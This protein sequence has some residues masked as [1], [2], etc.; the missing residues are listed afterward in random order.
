M[1]RVKF[2]HG[3]RKPGES[4]LLPTDPR[5]LARRDPLRMGWRF[6]SLMTLALVALAAHAIEVF[7]GQTW[8][9][10][11]IAPAIFAGIALSWW[12][13]MRS[14]RRKAQAYDARLDRIARQN[15]DGTR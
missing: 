10:I 11:P 2:L 3:V 6:V 9:L 14:I 13:G 12:A 4:P 7:G 1:K 5:R 8:W 15:R